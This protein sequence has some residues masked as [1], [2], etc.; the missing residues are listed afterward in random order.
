MSSQKRHSHATAQAVTSAS[1]VVMVGQAITTY[2]IS[3]RG[4]TQSDS[5]TNK[6]VSFVEQRHSSDSQQSLGG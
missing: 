3:V 6:E 1:L 5:R 4:A 2:L